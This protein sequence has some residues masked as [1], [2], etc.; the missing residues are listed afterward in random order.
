MVATSVSES[1]P[2][3]VHGE[4]EELPVEDEEDT[5]AVRVPSIEEKVLDDDLEMKFTDEDIKEI[6]DELEEE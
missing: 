5:E 2:R 3:P 1:V 4:V 6:M